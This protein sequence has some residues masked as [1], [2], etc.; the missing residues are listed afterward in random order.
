[1]MASMQSQ[2]G[3]NTT[4]DEGGFD[5]NNQ[6]INPNDFPFITQSDME[7]TDL[8]NLLWSNLLEDCDES[9]LS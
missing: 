5:S 8:N 2:P 7:F 6:S 1:M 3:L 4:S 9:I